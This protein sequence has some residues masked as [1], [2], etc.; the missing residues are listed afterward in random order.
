[1]IIVAGSRILRQLGGVVAACDLSGGREVWTWGAGCGPS[2]ACGCTA[3]SKLGVTS[4]VRSEDWAT[5]VLERRA[6]REAGNRA[7]HTFR[8]G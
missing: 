7:A 1:V 2:A 8:F 5:R 3:H 6:P 4:E